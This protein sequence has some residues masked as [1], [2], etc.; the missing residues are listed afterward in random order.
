MRLDLKKDRQSLLKYVK[1]RVRDYPIYVNDGPGED[2][3]EVTQIT[4]GF[5]CD[6]SGWVALVFDTRPK[7]ECDGEWQHFIEENCLELPH[8]CD[9]CEAMWEENSSVQLID[10]KGRK[11]TL[12]EDH[13]LAG[14]LGEFLQDFLIQLRNDGV[15]KKLPLSERCSLTVEEHDGQYGWTNLSSKDEGKIKEKAYAVTDQLLSQTKKWSK[16]KQIEFWIS[17]LVEI[18]DNTDLNPDQRHFPVYRNISALA[19]VGKPAMMPML[20]LASEL[21]AEPPF[22]GDGKSAREF[23]RTRILDSLINDAKQIGHVSP[24]IEKLLKEIVT[25]AVSV[26]YGRKTWGAAAYFAASALYALFK[27]YPCPE[28]AGNNELIGPQPF[29]SATS[30]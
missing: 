24:Q 1:Q 29:M 15:F 21:A 16:K 5:Q 8:W 14:V 25:K 2:E 27:D 26:N 13:S 4:C 11:E 12:G 23:Y 22:A 20:Q 9:V 28:M 30:K 17:R 3:D 7:S 19:A 18:A 6:Q 10:S